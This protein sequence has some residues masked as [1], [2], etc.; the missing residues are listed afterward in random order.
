MMFGFACRET[1]SLM[2]L[3]IELAHALTKRLAFVRQEEILPYLL[4][5]G[6]AQVTVE[7]RDGIPARV[8]TVVVSSQH[9]ADVSMEQLREDILCHVIQP[10]SL[11]VD[12]FGT[13]KFPAD[14]IQELILKTVDLRPSAII[15]RL[16][17]R[18]PFYRHTASY[19][20][21]GS[22]T[23]N[24]PWEQTNLPQLWQDII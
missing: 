8:E 16:S 18:T 14:Q 2:P 17:L 13:G 5:D 10:V 4:P 19:G 9:E 3:P 22:N 12:T 24:L 7:Y 6:K 15:D 21:F 23:A 11:L 1:D 20:H